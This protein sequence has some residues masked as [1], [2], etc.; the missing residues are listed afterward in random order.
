MDFPSLIL[1]LR[2]FV[3]LFGGGGAHA[4]NGYHLSVWRF[5]PVSSH[6]SLQNWPFSL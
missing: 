1:A 3:F 2:G 4:R 5:S 6:F